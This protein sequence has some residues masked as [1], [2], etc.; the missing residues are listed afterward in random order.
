[1]IL[2][3]LVPIIELKVSFSNESR[4]PPK[5]LTSLLFSHSQEDILYEIVLQVYQFI[6][7]LH[8]I[9]IQ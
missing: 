8:Q 2:I 4:P 7:Q 3:K 5:M 6:P 1:M 9:G